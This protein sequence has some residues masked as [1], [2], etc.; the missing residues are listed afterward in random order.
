MAV[1][2]CRQK[3]IIKVTFYLIYHHLYD[4]LCKISTW[5]DF[6]FN[7]VKFWQLILLKNFATE[8]EGSLRSINLNEL[9]GPHRQAFYPIGYFQIIAVMDRT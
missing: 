1:K 7:C 3:I 4:V 2:L 6:L 8:T 5:K 9:Q